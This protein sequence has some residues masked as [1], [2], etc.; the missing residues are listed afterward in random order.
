M[1]FCGS[2]NDIIWQWDV[3]ILYDVQTDTAS[4]SG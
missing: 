3:Y 1:A 4:L 2:G